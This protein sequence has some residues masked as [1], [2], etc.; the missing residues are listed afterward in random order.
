MRILLV[1]DEAELAGAMR[2]V[3]EREGYVVDHVTGLADLREAARLANSD[4]VLLDRALP[5]GDGVEAIAELRHWIPGIPVIVITARAE[6]EDRVLGLDLGADDYL[7][8]P[9]AMEELLAR[10]RAIRR[11]PAALPLHEVQVGELVYD[12]A[13]DEALVRGERLD[14]PRREL[15]VL[16]ALMRRR[17]RT[18]LR[19]AL[20]DAVYGF[21]DEIQSN[22]LDS[23]ISRLRRRL[24]EADAEVQIH[25]IR[26]VGYL[27]RHCP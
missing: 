2:T 7:A 1:E 10:I 18:V 24:S 16:A 11:R 19:T 26:G 21:D 14:L 20:E 5:D 12:M 8:K 27:L 3:L 4:A 25:T 23:H 22:T 13:H 17:G 9:F 15:R 6:V